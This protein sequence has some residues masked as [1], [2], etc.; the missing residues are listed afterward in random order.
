MNVVSLCF[1]IFYFAYCVQYMYQIYIYIYTLF[2]YLYSYVHTCIKLMNVNWPMM[3]NKWTRVQIGFL[4]CASTGNWWLIRDLSIKH[5][6]G[7]K[8]LR[9]CGGYMIHVDWVMILGDSELEAPAELGIMIWPS[10]RSSHSASIKERRC[11]FWPSSGRPATTNGSKSGDK[12][13][14]F[15]FFCVMFVHF[16]RETELTVSNQIMLFD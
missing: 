15:L 1:M 3:K 11:R 16:D 7:I 12:D 10:V 2:W 13:K 4:K 9:C 14:R 8:R 6:M 5:M